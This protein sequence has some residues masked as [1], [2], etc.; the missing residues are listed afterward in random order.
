LGGVLSSSYSLLLF[1][2]SAYSRET[3]HP[4]RVTEVGQKPKGGTKMFNGYM[5]RRWLMERRSED[6][7][8][9][10]RNPRCCP[11][12]TFLLKE[13]G[14]ERVAVGER[15]FVVRPGFVDER[16]Y[17]LPSWGRRFVELID[18]SG[19]E[20]GSE[21]TAGVALNILRL[22]EAEFDLSEEPTEANL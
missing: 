15:F 4:A 8:G 6:V 22:V 9:V 7:V 21:V 5:F 3:S 11:L 18:A 19:G 17:S 14:V 12:A 1:F 20:D 13:L 16:G 2:S 10:S